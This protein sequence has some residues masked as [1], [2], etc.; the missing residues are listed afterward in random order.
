MMNK[1]HINFVHQTQ[2]QRG[3]K[4]GNIIL[5]GSGLIICCT[6]AMY[7]SFIN[8][9]PVVKSIVEAPVP[10]EVPIGSL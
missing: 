8:C 1:H 9:G 2:T 5:E 4:S 3:A 7:V 10:D 6:H